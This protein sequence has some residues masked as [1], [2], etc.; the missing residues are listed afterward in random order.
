MREVVGVPKTCI[1]AY[2]KPISFWTALLQY[3]D[4]IVVYESGI[5]HIPTF[6]C[7]I[8]VVGKTKSIRV[9][10]DTPYIKGLPVTLTIREKIDGRPGTDANGVQERIV[11]QT[12]EDPYTLEWE[13]FYE[14]IVEGKYPK[15]SAKDSRDDLDIYK[16]ILQAGDRQQARI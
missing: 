8:E 4:F 3:D 14:C 10:F 9:T 5:N 1:A 13:H 15:T 7:Y 16:M 2:Y 6:D 12:Y 11:R